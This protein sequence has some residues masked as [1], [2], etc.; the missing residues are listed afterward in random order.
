MTRI[1]RAIV[2]MGVMSALLSAVACGDDDDPVVVIESPIDDS[3]LTIADDVDPVMDGIQIAVDVTVMDE[4]EGEEVW[5]YTDASVLME[6]P[7][8]EPTLVEPLTAEGAV[9]FL[10]TL[11]PGVHDLLACVRDC[12]Y[13]SQQ[14]QVTVVAGC[15]GI[16]FIDPS[17]TAGDFTVLGPDDDVDDDACGANFTTNVRVTTTAAD[18][19]SLQLFVNGTPGPTTTAFG[20][21]ARFDGVVLGARA[22]DTNS[23]SV[24]LTDD[25]VSCSQPFPNA[26]RVDCE[27]TS[28]AITLPEPGRSFLNA[29]DDVSAADG[30]QADFEV[31]AGIEAEGETFN[32]IVD[33]EILSRGSTA[34]GGDAVAQFDAIDLSEGRHSV[35]AECF[36]ALGNMTRTEPALWVVDTIPCDVSVTEPSADT[37]FVDED[38]VDDGSAGIQ[39]G[40]SGT[41][42]GDACT[43]VAAGPCGG[44]GEDLALTGTSFSGNATLAST[45]MQEM[46]VVVTDEAG[47]TGEARIP[48]RVRTDAPQLQIA[49]PTAGTAFN[50]TGTMGATADLDPG[51]D[52]CDVAA[53]VFCTEVGEPVDIE[54]VASGTLLGTADCVAMAGLP[55]PFTGQATFTSIPVPSRNNG[56]NVNIVARQTVD[57]VEGASAP[58][59]LAADCDEPTLTFFSPMCGAVLSPTDDDE[60]PGTPGFQ[61]TVRVVNQVDNNAD[62]TT[63]TAVDSGGGTVLSQMSMTRSASSIIFDAD[64]G[65][66]GELTMRACAT[67]PAGNVG[68]TMDCP[69]TILDLPEL[70]IT[71]PADGAALNGADDCAPGT[72]GMQVR[73]TGTTDA[74]DSAPASITFGGLAPQ[75]VAISGGAIDACVDAQ[76][77]GGISVVLEVDAGGGTARATVMVDVDSMPPTAVVSDLA[78]DSAVDRRGGIARLTYTAISDE[79]GSTLD[80]TEIRCAR[81]TIDDESDWSAAAVFA[82][83]SSASPGSVVLEDVPGFA[84]GLEYYCLARSADIGGNVSPLPAGGGT[85]VLLDFLSVSVESGSS[86]NVG[87]A[88]RPVGDIDGDLL[89]DFIVAGNNEVHIFFGRT[90]IP[91]GPVAPDVTIEGDGNFGGLAGGDIAG[92]GDF[93]GDLRADF[94]VGASG[95]SSAYV[96]FGRASRA[97]WPT[98]ITVSETECPA[99]ARAL[100]IRGTAG[101]F[102]GYHVAAAGD[103]NGDG[104][105]D[106]AV[107]TFAA[108][109]FVG[110]QQVVLGASSFTASS[111]RG[112]ST[113][114]GFDVRSAG[115]ALPNQFIGSASASLGDVTGDGRAD[116]ILGASGG[117]GV[118]GRARRLN[119]RD[120][121]GTPGLDTINWDTLTEIATGPAGRYAGDIY[122]LGDVTGGGS[123]DVGIFNSSG[124]G[125]LAVFTGESNFTVGFSMTSDLAASA[126]DG[127]GSRSGHSMH[128]ALGG[129]GQLDGAAGPEILLAS[130]QSG[131]D[132]GDA[133]LWY[134]PVSSATVR[135][136]ADVVFAPEL[137]AGEASGQVAAGFVGDINGDGHPDLA[138]GE[139]NW[140]TG[141]AGT[142]TGRVTLYY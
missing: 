107:G 104:I 108:D 82:L 42:A 60:E 18:G 25:G 121:S 65:A 38:D 80:L 103:F 110:A 102:F 12:S 54:A 134:A 1:T 8:A 91:A 130:I 141:L 6:T 7:E 116:L 59:A 2:R 61:Y 15:G 73:V 3:I 32:L 142:A 109:G 21:Q 39:V 74:A 113:L 55:A 117:G 106:L 88:M 34:V 62:L 101:E 79:D 26:I 11:E 114:D 139:P 5:L 27:G 56:T 129:V 138:V 52:A 49:T 20:G 140:P 125:S 14:V 35:V 23:L 92:L 115:M 131:T 37:L 95:S 78:V 16:T 4:A 98:S 10:T 132:A 68:C 57:R 47:N 70:S 85:P 66:G 17:P 72:P 30:F 136:S 67:D 69:I 76:E 123:I 33:G 28:C 13:R 105:H 100:C 24:T 83:R 45:P 94:A 86:A 96:F 81:E 99:S 31:T 58:I 41:V 9:S 63:L 122:S 97:A 112:I 135:S 126:G 77:G 36:D 87:E 137:E 71:S 19:A 75:S 128:A 124:A 133:R 111:V 84:T 53:T 43:D 127:F 119:G 22:P 64:F 46:C 51:T 40:V 50:E 90:T 120:H 89:D 44:M 29:S 48:L 93:N 118:L